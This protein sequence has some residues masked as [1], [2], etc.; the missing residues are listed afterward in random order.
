MFF[1]RV[2]PLRAESPRS[3]GTSQRAQRA[4]K[5]AMAQWERCAKS[6]LSVTLM[7]A[8]LGSIG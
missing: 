8:E 5:L 7:A 3:R 1:E 2:G 6:R 4:V